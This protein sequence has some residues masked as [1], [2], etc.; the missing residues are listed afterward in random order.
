MRS[1]SNDDDQGSCALGTGFAS[2][3]SG[4]PQSYLSTSQLASHSQVRAYIYMPNP[5]VS[6]FIY[7]ISLC[8][9]F[10]ELHSMAS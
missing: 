10:L 1:E 4:T 7:D 5:L 6:C 8:V 2:P 9:F 3:V